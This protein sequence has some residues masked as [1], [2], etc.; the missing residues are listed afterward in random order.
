LNNQEKVVT[1][2]TIH[3]KLDDIICSATD[4]IDW[5]FWLKKQRTDLTVERS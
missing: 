4:G 2:E 5:N 3:F 1:G